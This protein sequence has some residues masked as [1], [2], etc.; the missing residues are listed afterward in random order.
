MILWR[1][2]KIENDYE[3]LTSLDWAK[4]ELSTIEYDY[5]I[6]RKVV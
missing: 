1:K 6:I 4:Y 2:I 5:K 3:N